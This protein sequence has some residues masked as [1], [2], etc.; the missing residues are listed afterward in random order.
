M[1]NN[2][3]DQ[4]TSSFVLW[5]PHQPTAGPTLVLGKFQ[6]GA[7]PTLTN[8]QRFDLK[9]VDGVSGLWSIAA[10]DCS[11][12]DGQVYHYW[13]EVDDTLPGQP[14]DPRL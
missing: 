13:F 1:S 8:K 7:P 11:L 10:T 9:A 6:E 12:R 4:R 2:L 5:S 3:L 14:A